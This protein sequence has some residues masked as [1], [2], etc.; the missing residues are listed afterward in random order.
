LTLEEPGWPDVAHR[1]IAK[2]STSD[3][4][5]VAAVFLAVVD[6]IVVANRQPTAWEAG[7][8]YAALCEL[9]IGREENARRRIGLALLPGAKQELPVRRF[10]L[11]TA[12]ELLQALTLISALNGASPGG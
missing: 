10:P 7:C 2:L 11:P 9:A 3:G 8:L 1:V 5:G 4:L 12:E 6:R